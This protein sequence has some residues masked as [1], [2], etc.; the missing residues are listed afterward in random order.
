MFMK[1]LTTNEQAEL[2]TAAIIYTMI[3][4]IGFYLGWRDNVYLIMIIAG[5]GLFVLVLLLLIFLVYK[6]VLAF[7]QLN[8]K[9]NE[10]HNN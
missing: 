4:G 1:A 6:I 2:I 8:N 9:S 7:L 5:T 3:M 10:N